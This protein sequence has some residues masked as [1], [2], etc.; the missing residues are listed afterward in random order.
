MLECPSPCV[1]SKEQHGKQ[2]CLE[3]IKHVTDLDGKKTLL[4]Y[5]SSSQVAAAE[6]SAELTPCH[7]Q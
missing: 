7:Q 4:K 3:N 5:L 6:A 2:R 1:F